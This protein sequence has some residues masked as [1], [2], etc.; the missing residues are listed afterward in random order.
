M[1]S[2]VGLLIRK[3]RES[4]DLTREQAAKK[5]G[6][7]KGYLAILENDGHVRLSDDLI[8]KLVTKLGVKKQ[9][10]KLQP[11]HNAKAKKVKAAYPSSQI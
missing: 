3:A 9:I 1:K 10:L 7:S 5:I 4:R 8:G 11:A 2:T 6:I